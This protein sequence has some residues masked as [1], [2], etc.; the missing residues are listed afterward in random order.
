MH[1]V[2]LL[3]LLSFR[4]A[5]LAQAGGEDWTG[6]PS[7]SN[8]GVE[9][10]SPPEPVHAA[11][12]L[13]PDAGVLPKVANP[14]PVAPPS[15]SEA[16]RPSAGEEPA[17][18]KEAR[19]RVERRLRQ[20]EGEEAPVAEEPKL[21]STRERFLPGSEPHSPSTWGNGLF[22]AGNLRVSPG[23]VG[24]GLLQV[25]SADLGRKGLVRFS[26]LGEYAG[27]NHFP[28][29]GAANVRSASTFA[30][31]FVF[32]DWAEAYLSYAAMANSNTRSSPRLILA[33]GD[34][35]WGVRASRKWSRGLYAG[36]DARLLTFSGV[37]N[38]GLDRWAVGFS[39]R[40]LASYDLREPLPK[41]PLRAHANLGLAFDSTGGWVRSHQLTV[42]EEF[43]LSVNRY[44][45][46][47]VGMALEAPLPVV[48]PFLEY[49]FAAPLGV[50]NG[51][52]VGPDQVQVPVA[53]AMAQSLGLGLK[54]TAIKDLTLM[55]AMDFGL[56]RYVGLGVP[57]TQ[58]FNL[59]LGAAFNVDPFQRGETKVVETVQERAVEKPVEKS[60]VTGKVSGKVVDKATGKPIG[61]VV[62]AMV[63]A[64]LP[65]VA[66]D[67]ESGVFLTHEL[68]GGPVRLSAKK[69][70]Y[71][72]TSQE[73]MAE[74]GKTVTVDLALEGELRRAGFEVKVTGKKKPLAAA[75]AF[76]GARDQQGATSPTGEPLQLELPA[77]KYSVSVSADGHLAQTREVQVS[78][79]AKMALS[80]ELLP[81]P[82]KKLVEVKEGRIEL[83]QQV[84]FGTAKATILADSTNLLQQVVDAIV[85]HKLKRLRV[86]GHTDSRGNKEN[87][88]KLSQDRAKAV[89]DFL[90][91]Q[92]IEASRVE[93][94]GHGDARPI[95]PNL[96]ARGRELNRRVEFHIL[97]R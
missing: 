78:E 96:T 60:P 43:A 19:Q 47:A 15:P 40:L 59:L 80:F 93:S 38:Q 89:A 87:N 77:G 16:A 7:P 31:S 36:V 10:V 83:L 68:P 73:L 18:V 32:H 1:R 54:L 9:A 84:H 95:A 2:V 76:A 82:A 11:P 69:E 21:V 92:G 97:E 64:G 12:R 28:V 27:L 30:A 58:P 66:S 29:K 4:G 51:K 81:Q 88:R 13:A 39:P 23:A 3:V 63:G 90:V 67:P 26:V 53:Q 20:A 8:P 50:P 46:L 6:F 91:G 56:S 65:P 70:G 57:A 44:N 14:Q 49:R 41:V 22:S 45:R 85:R 94:V 62:V 75:V 34:I 17:G 72:E 42:T 35:T 74:G 24:V 33:M 5:A 48:S 25:G 86:E 37:G 71:K 79:G 61:G 52:L 55:A